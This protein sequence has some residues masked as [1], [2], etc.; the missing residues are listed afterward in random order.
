MAQF[1]FK[2]IGTTWVIDIFEDI[3]K[4]KEAQVLYLV[5]ARIDDFDKA[6]SRFRS[7]SLVSEISEKAGTYIFGEDSKELFALYHELYNRTGGF[8][9]PLIGQ[10]LVDA[11]YDA[12][13]SLKQKKELSVPPTWES[14]MDFSFPTL[15]TKRPIKLDFGA[16][17]KG[18]IIDLIGQVLEKEGIKKYYID[19]GGDIRQRGSESMRIGLEHPQNE[20]QAIGVYSLQNRSICG[21]AGN[22]RKWKNFNH[23]INPKTLSSPKNIIAVWAVADT[24]FL[25]DAL[26][27]CLFFVPAGDLTKFY[28]FEYLLIHDDLSV[29]KSANFAGEI[30]T[31]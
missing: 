1:N 31:V 25:A 18:Y 2:A 16:A 19:A 8:F 4:E 24:T 12:E 17:G 29:E 6:Y 13:Y 9:T 30:F 11:G 20:T 10:L 21:S 26:T 7:D 22:R 5:M 3:T 14:V 23:I 28:K 15:T 27:T